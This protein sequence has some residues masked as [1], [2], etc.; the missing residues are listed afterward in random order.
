P[1]PPRGPSPAVPNPRR[2]ARSQSKASTAATHAPVMDAVRVPPSATSTSQSSLMVY[3][4]NRKSSSIARMLRPIRRWISCVRPPSCVRSRDV[5]VRVARG[6]IAY[7]AVSQPSPRP[8]RQ[9]GTP[10]STDAVQRTR[11]AP[12]STRH[13]PSAYGATPRSSVIGRR[14]SFVREVRFGAVSAG[15]QALDGRRRGVAGSE[16]NDNDLSAPTA[17]FG[18]ADDAIGVV[19]PPFDENIGLERLN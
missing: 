11:V 18:S 17:H 9:E 3:S 6:S 2:P 19:V 12:N 7:S 8:R 1:P 15:T 16:R 4:P 14:S 10:S 13:D 5:R